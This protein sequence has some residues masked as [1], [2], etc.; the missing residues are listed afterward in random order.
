MTLNE[1][2]RRAERAM[3]ERD[4]V[5]VKLIRAKLMLLRI[6][7]DRL[8]GEAMLYPEAASA[9]KELGDV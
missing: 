4:R 7:L 5:K 1:T 3:P 8:A 6:K 9:L 2:I